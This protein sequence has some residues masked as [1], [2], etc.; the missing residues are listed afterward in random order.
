MKSFTFLLLLTMFLM[1]VASKALPFTN[2]GGV[3]MYARP[4]ENGRNLILYVLDKRGFVLPLTYQ[5]G[6]SV[7]YK[8]YQPRPAVNAIGSFVPGDVCNGFSA[9]GTIL[10]LGTSLS[11]GF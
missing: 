2:F 11:I 8:M 3:I 7:L 1:P 4:C 6:F 5:P 10:Q 9:V